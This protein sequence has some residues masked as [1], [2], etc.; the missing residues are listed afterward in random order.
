M[1]N[2]DLRLTKLRTRRA[3]REVEDDEE[4]M[5][6]PGNKKKKKGRGRLQRLGLKKKGKKKK[7]KGDSDSSGTDTD[8]SDSDISESDEEGGSKRRQSIGGTPETD[9]ARAARVKVEEHEKR[10]ARATQLYNNMDSKGTGKLK[11]GEIAAAVRLQSKL[12][13]D[14][15]IARPM[16]SVC[17]FRPV[18][19]SV[20]VFRPVTNS[21]CIFRPVAI[22]WDTCR[23]L[24][25][26]NSG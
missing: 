16:I 13:S 5:S 7:K 26:S 15:A 17:V 14:A 2:K 12:V 24:F 11:A 22:V 1:K 10:H 3:W 8:F 4:G 23:Q 9:A 6:S 19:N 18:T 20:C 21:V 25:L